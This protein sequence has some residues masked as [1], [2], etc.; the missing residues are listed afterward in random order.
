MNQLV[1]EAPVTETPP[2]P[3]VDL[4]PS[5]EPI[6][7]DWGSVT[8]VAPGADDGSTDTTSSDDLEPPAAPAADTPPPPAEPAPAPAPAALPSPPPAPQIPQPSAEERE[9]VAVET[10]G[11]II[12]ALADHY[13]SMINEDVARELAIN[14]EKVI[15]NLLANAIF[16][17]VTTMQ[18]M[19]TQQAPQ[20][21]QQVAA[22]E[23]A[24]EA[25]ANEFF[26]VNSDLKN[27]EY[28]ST[29]EAAALAFKHANPNATRDQAIKGVGVI[30]R[31]M[32]GKTQSAGG[33]PAPAQT[34]TRPAAF[35]PVA[36]GG[37]SPRSPTAKPKG[38][39]DDLV[40]PD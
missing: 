22:Q 21:V 4:A 25:V 13:T 29:L 6:D 30:A 26:S 32:L 17:A 18:G 3:V 40:S 19:M 24:R 8:N 39:W 37:H 27:P 20:L 5:D 36:A 14:P 1:A 33:A 16:D 34:T 9:R 15:P 31:A 2:A 7:V 11:K 10:K 28:K 12:G 23:K 35:I 38:E